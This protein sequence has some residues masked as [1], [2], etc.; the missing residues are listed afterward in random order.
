MNIPVIL[1]TGRKGNSS[2]NVALLIVKRIKASGNKSQLV[3]PNDHLKNFFTERIDIERKGEKYKKIIEKA[4]SIVVVIPE[5][6]RSFPG[7]LKLLVD[8][9]Y[10]Q[11]KGKKFYMIG[12]SSGGTGGSR[13]VESF[14]HV[15]VGL[16]GVPVKPNLIFPNVG[17]L[18]DKKGK[19][20]DEKTSERVDQFVESLTS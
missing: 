9:L 20:T 18:F 14:I 4:D 15:V 5:Y 6:N 7:E 17:D 10:M 11:Y 12:V 19:L 8:S 3:D 16:Q 1:G 2:S 13:A